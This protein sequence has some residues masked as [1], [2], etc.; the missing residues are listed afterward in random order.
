MADIYV[1]MPI[2][3]T[4]PL[5]VGRNGGRTNGSG[6]GNAASEGLAG[7]SG[8]VGRQRGYTRALLRR[9]EEPPGITV[10]PG[11]DSSTSA[12]RRPT[13]ARPTSTG[14]ARI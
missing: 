3:W 5:V 11:K 13:Y 7:L 1:D 14:G 10:H 9:V 12:D 2:V 8:G 4:R 6:V